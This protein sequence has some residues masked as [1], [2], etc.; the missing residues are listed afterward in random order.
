MDVTPDE[1]SLAREYSSSYVLAIETLAQLAVIW[2][3]ELVA[4]AAEAGAGTIVVAL[5]VLDQL[6]VAPDA[7]A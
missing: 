2:V 1:K 6:L 7:T 5:A 4:A 3:A